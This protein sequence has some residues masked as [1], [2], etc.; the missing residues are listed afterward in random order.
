MRSDSHL[1]R[2]VKIVKDKWLPII[3]L[4]LGINAI[5][6]MISGIIGWASQSPLITFIQ[7]QYQLIGL[8]ALTLFVIFLFTQ[9]HTVNKR[10]TVGFSENHK[11]TLADNWDYRGDWTIVDGK[12]LQ[13]TSSE[14]G[15]ITK[16]GVLWEN[17]TFKFQ[18][19]I[20]ETCLGAIVR[21]E[22]LNHYYM[23][24]INPDKIR[25]HLRLNVPKIT[26]GE[27]AGLITIELQNAWQNLK[28][29][30]ISP[31]GNG[32]FDAEIRVRGQRVVIKIN[33]E[34]V[35]DK[36]GYLQIPFGKVG[37]RNYGDEK[38]LIRNIEVILE[39]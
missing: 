8:L 33:G 29:I 31:V 7:T 39:P 23:F 25:P 27:T 34:V 1:E 12:M 9:L 17:Y 2:I 19:R 28:D 15:G 3:S 14:Q 22:N 16:T 36:D 35:F 10:L 4:I 37:F 20:I 30:P 11:R 26:S 21:A 24:Q 32:W 38:A 6:G 13:V 5:I 18:A